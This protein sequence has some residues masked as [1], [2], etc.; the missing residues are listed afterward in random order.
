M[1]KRLKITQWLLTGAILLFSSQ[2]FA[3]V[4]PSLQW[5]NRV[6]VLHAVSEYQSLGGEQV[7]M[8][9]SYAAEMEERELIVLNL[10]SR[11]L[12]KVPNLSPFPFETRILDDREERRYLLSQFGGDDLLA[13][14][15]V[16]LV[17]LDGEIKQRW[18][19]VVEPS[20]IFDAIDAMPMRMR[21]IEQE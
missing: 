18:D 4:F 1:S 13:G 5:N 10:T 7:A 6:L 14:L 16:S 21:E 11:V 9:S 20:E 15:R 2:V 3:Q 8:L 19:G 12:E 17:G